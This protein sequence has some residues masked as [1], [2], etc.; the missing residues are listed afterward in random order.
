MFEIFVKLASTKK[1]LSYSRDQIFAFS[2]TDHKKKPLEFY[3]STIF[4]NEA[5]TPLFCFIVQFSVY[6]LRFKNNE[7]YA[8]SDQMP[9]VQKLSSG[10]NK[11]IIC[12]KP[13]STA[14]VELN[15]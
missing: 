1:R 11:Q 6:Y 2:K 7:L 13:S 9:Q 10:K 5:T 8:L 3:P 4:C 15:K 14:D 12:K